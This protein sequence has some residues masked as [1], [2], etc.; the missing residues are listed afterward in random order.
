M[1]TPSSSIIAAAQEQW[2]VTDAHG[3][4]LVLRRLDAL[5]KL[6]LFRA[7]GPALSQNEP[8]LGMV[9][10]AASVAAIDQ[11]PMPIPGSEAVIEDVV[12]RLGDVGLAAVAQALRAEDPLDLDSAKN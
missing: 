2:A 9:L 10:L 6:R 7:L 12:K 11:V 4:R 3:R 1:E 5:G 8:Y